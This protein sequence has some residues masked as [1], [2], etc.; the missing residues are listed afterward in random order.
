MIITK[1]DSFVW[2][3]I[4]PVQAKEIFKC[5]ALELYVIHDDE[6][7]SLLESEDELNFAIENN[8]L[9]CIE[10]GRLPKKYIQGCSWNKTK[11]KVID[12]FWYVKLSDIC[13]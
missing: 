7:E 10:V 1:R 4:S 11:R 3:D 9:I 8:M 13:N 2:R 12:G 5:N 6:T